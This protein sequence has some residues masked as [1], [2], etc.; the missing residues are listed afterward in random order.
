MVAYGIDFE[1]NGITYYGKLIDAKN[2]ESAK[3]K[4]E[5]KYGEIKIIKSTVIGY[6]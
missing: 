6:Y 5:R 1:R 4:L 2:F 3:K